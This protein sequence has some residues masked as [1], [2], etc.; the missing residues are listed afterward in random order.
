[1]NFDAATLLD[2]F[3]LYRELRESAPVLREEDLDFWMLFRHE[4]VKRALEDV[5]VFSSE[6]PLNLPPSAAPDNMI[7][8][9]DPKHA[10]LRAFAQ[11]AFTP[12]R[13]AKLEQQVQVLCDE[14]LA[15]MAGQGDA[16]DLVSAF[17]GPLPAMVIAALL[18]VPRSD[19]PT[20]REL[21]REAVYITM[22]PQAERGHR[23]ME[24]L[25]AFY[26]ELVSTK[27]R[28]GELGDDLTGDLLRAQ[29]SGADFSDRELLAMGPL[30]LIAGHET[31]TNLINNTVRSLSETPGARDFLCADLG[32]TPLILEEVLRYRGT[33]NGLVRL[34][35]KAVVLQGQTI[36]A[37]GRVLAVVAAA[38]HDPRVFDHPDTFLPERNPRNLLSFG[39]GVHR[40]IGE[41]LA[42]LESRVALPALYRRFPDLRVDPD[43]PAVPTPSAMIHGCLELPVRV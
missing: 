19:V 8:N 43:C 22:P 18:G 41:P 29:A 7:F 9:D 16:F 37:G 33:A 27:R 36:P 6:N 1:M 17:S 42:R 4:D 13:V 24:R 31:T 40:C 38:N 39:R 23:A 35:R 14:L 25:V 11:P 34:A 26:G 20:F 5:E 2:P 28:G 30:F 15:E 12:R 3:P 21:A 10:R 32:R